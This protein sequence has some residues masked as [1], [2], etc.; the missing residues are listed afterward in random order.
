M[1]LFV[2]NVLDSKGELYTYNVFRIHN[3]MEAMRIQSWTYFNQELHDIFD[4]RRNMEMIRRTEHMLTAECDKAIACDSMAAAAEVL[5]GVPYCCRRDGSLDVF[6]VE[7]APTLELLIDYC[8]VH[9]AEGEH[10]V[11]AGRDITSPAT[12]IDRTR[13]ITI[14]IVDV[15]TLVELSVRLAKEAK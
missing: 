2:G 15:R 9:C 14:D 6:A 5:H 3:F 8:L 1:Q 12:Y 7:A 4:I 13:N 11:Y 10:V